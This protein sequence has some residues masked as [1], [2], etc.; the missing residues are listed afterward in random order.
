MHYNETAVGDLLRRRERAASMDKP[1]KVLGDLPIF[2]FFTGAGFLD[3]G[4]ESCGFE[5]K[6]INEYHKPFVDGYL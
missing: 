5:T 3:F 6:M 4:F 1:S 2:S